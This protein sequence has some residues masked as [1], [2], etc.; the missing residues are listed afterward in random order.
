MWSM[1]EA[2]LVMAASPAGPMGGTHGMGGS[3]SDD[4]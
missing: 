4:G 2:W 1:V 3:G